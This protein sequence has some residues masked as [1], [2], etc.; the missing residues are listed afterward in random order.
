MI[1]VKIYFS[2]FSQFNAI[3]PAARNSNFQAEEED[4]SQLSSNMRLELC[5]NENEFIV[6]LWRS[7]SL[8]RWIMFLLW[9]AFASRS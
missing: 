5:E 7:P 6:L 4:I 9:N 3:F 2:I 8:F 1:L